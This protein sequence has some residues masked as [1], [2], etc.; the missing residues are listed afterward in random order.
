M[1]INLAPDSP[2]LSVATESQAWA[3]GQRRSWRRRNRESRVRE[4]GPLRGR[5]CCLLLR[6]LEET[7][8]SSFLA[9]SSNAGEL[10]S[11]KI[12][13]SYSRIY[14]SIGRRSKYSWR[15]SVSTP[16]CIRSILVVGFSNRQPVLPHFF[17][18][19]YWISSS[20]LPSRI[21]LLPNETLPFPVSPWS[22]Q[23]G[24]M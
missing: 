4:L 15:L 23:T 1:R 18:P 12:R 6:R 21:C 8:G 7:L 20:P 24:P 11:L 2:C 5:P 9:A 13:F 14:T 3:F 17:P 10:A 19:N 16:S 22:V